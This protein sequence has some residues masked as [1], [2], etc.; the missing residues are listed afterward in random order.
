MALS[1]AD[2]GRS[3]DDPGFSNG[4]IRPEMRFLSGGPAG[5]QKIVEDRCF[6]AKNAGDRVMYLRMVNTFAVRWRRRRISLKVFVKL[7]L[8][9]RLGF[10]ALEVAALTIRIVSS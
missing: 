6:P 10:V 7:R 3:S 8:A 5:E 9:T 2:T 4:T 1:Y